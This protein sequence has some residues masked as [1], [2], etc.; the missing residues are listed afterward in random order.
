NV[1]NAI[2]LAQPGS[3]N[4][5]HI[6]TIGTTFAL[7][8]TCLALVA[9]TLLWLH[10]L[11]VLLP[12]ALAAVLIIAYNAYAAELRKRK[13][14]DMLV[15]STRIAHGSARIESVTRTL[16]ARAREMFVAERAEM[17]IFPDH[18]E[19]GSRFVLEAGDE[20]DR[21]HVPALDP[22]EGIWA[23]ILL[24]GR[25][26]RLARPIEDEPL[27]RHYEQRGI[28]DLM[29]APIRRGDEII[30]KILVANRRSD[31]V[32]FSV[33]DLHLFETLANHASVS[34][35]NGRLVDEL[36]QQLAENQ[37]QALHDALTGLPNRT[38]FRQRLDQA[39]SARQG[40]DHVA[41]VMMDLDHFKEVNDTLGHYV[42][43]LLLKEVAKRLELSLDGQ[44]TIARLSGD[45]FG[46]LITEFDDS[47]QALAL[48]RHIIHTL[49]APFS[50]EELT[51][52]VGASLGIALSPE[53]GVGADTLLQR[54]DVAMYLAKEAR[55]GVEVYS[56]ERDQ[57]SPA[58]LAL[59]GE[60][61]R[62]LEQRELKVFYQAKAD[63]AGRLVGAEALVRWQHPERG[64]I[65]PDE[66]V[67]MA[68]HTGLI[69][70]LTIYVLEE[71]VRQ[72]RDLRN[73]GH[74]LHVAVNL[75]VRNLL[76]AELP[77]S[78]ARILEHHQL[79]ASWLKLEITESIIMADTARTETVLTRLAGMGVGISIDD[80]GTGLSSY[81][82]L[83]RLPV[84]ELKIDRSFILAMDSGGKAGKIVRSIIDLGHNLGLEVVAEGIET[85]TAWNTLRQLGCDIAQGYL[86]SRPV[87]IEEFTELLRSG[88]H[89]I[90]EAA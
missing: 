75:S 10:P 24:H 86:I 83:Q 60:I 32:T 84:D 18:G 65:L 59:G 51:L 16:L 13:S 80:F 28:R 38:L 5:R 29:A 35:Q 53:H 89:P 36:R 23:E 48:A 87:P 34:L 69:R 85:P 26:V 2:S 6:L 9:V 37:H 4:R 79:P 90:T 55:S 52:Q 20:F 7:A 44:T 17:L 8:N 62:A 39:L 88:Q 47:G 66:F 67:P 27:R 21:L 77:D 54:A 73:A 11:T 15:E 64:L 72:C 71:A 3:V 22:K 68:E 45:E 40:G 81:Q 25:G 33:D 70:P 61:R 76:D 41:V 50:L 46:L 1:A 74:E 43:D 19:P 14:M 57:Y 56:A 63:F 82:R 30:G 31:V 58:R 78:I 12:M 42:G 49:E